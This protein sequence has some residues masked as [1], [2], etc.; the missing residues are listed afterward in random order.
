MFE[1]GLIDIAGIAWVGAAIRETV[2]CIIFENLSSLSLFHSVS[3]L[4]VIGSDVQ[5][6]LTLMR[7][8]GR[9]HRP[10]LIHALSLRLEY[11]T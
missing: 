3:A 11:V 1:N 6:L 5:P 8:V 7:P 4:D 2:C 10:D 9:E